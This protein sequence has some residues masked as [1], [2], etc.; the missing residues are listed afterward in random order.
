MSASSNASASSV[1]DL[2]EVGGLYSRG[3]PSP[4]SSCTAFGVA[5]A[6]DR[7][8]N[9]AARVRRG[10]MRRPPTRCLQAW[11]MD[12][13]SGRG[14][15]LRAGCSWCPG[16]SLVVGPVSELLAPLFSEHRS[17]TIP[18]LACSLL[19]VRRQRGRAT[20]AVK[21]AVA[22]P[23]LDGNRWDNEASLPVQFDI[24]E[25]HAPHELSALPP[26]GIASWGFLLK[27]HQEQGP[28]R[29]NPSSGLLGRAFEVAQAVHPGFIQDA[30]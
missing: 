18:L 12:T 28:R 29:I 9:K 7:T 11:R 3:A 17:E 4:V 13:G 23:G 26:D 24:V 15:P 1:T 14:K 2:F 5:H 16:H 27:L 21:D 19:L 22:A 25:P 8:R 20:A 6:V 30:S 10:S